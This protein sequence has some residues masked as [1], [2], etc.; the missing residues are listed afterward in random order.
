MRAVDKLADEIMQMD[1]E[2]P[3]Y[4]LSREGA[5]FRE[6]EGDLGGSQGPRAGRPAVTNDAEHREDTEKAITLTGEQ[7]YT[8]WAREHGHANGPAAGLSF[9]GFLRAMVTGPRNDAER[10]ALSEGTDSAGG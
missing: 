10:R 1:P 5:S 9:G 4:R 7:R 6:I 2:G 3:H 8:D